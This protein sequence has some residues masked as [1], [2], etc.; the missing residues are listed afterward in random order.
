MPNGGYSTDFL[1]DSEDM[2]FVEFYYE[3]IEI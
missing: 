3:A 1:G 2:G